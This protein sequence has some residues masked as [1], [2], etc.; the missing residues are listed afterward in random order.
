[1][2]MDTPIKTEREKKA[3]DGFYFWQLFQFALLINIAL[4]II[5]IAHQGEKKKGRRHIFEVPSSPAPIGSIYTR[6]SSH[7]ETSSVHA[8]IQA[9]SES[10][11]RIFSFNSNLH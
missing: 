1:M 5:E 9:H 3:R 10:H 8:R 4:F 7:H 6:N 11:A 2:D